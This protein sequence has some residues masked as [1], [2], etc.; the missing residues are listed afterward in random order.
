M[1]NATETDSWKSGFTQDQLSLA[2]TICQGS[3]SVK[4]QVQELFQELADPL[5]SVGDVHQLLGASWLVG[6]TQQQLDALVAD[7]V[8]EKSTTTICTAGMEDS[9]Y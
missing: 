5:L 3:G 1:S 4:E 9:H 7:G 2:A 6:D 8:L